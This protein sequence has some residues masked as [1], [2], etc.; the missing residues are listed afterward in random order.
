MLK[1]LYFLSEKRMTIKILARQGLI[2]NKGNHLILD[3]YVYFSCVQTDSLQLND[4]YTVDIY[5]LVY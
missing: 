5:F 2:C 3:Q 4:T 1:I